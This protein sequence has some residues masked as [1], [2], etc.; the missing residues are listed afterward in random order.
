MLL[1]PNRKEYYYDK[2]HK[3]FVNVCMAATV[4]SGIA[5]IYSG[6]LFFTRTIPEHKQLMIEKNKELLEEGKDIEDSVPA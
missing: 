3:G 1:R 6:Y 4:I 2:F 5:L